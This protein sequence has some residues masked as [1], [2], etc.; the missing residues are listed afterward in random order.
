MSA[1]QFLF[2]V[3]H[4]CSRYTSTSVLDAYSK[5]AWMLTAW[6]KPPKNGLARQRLIEFPQV[7]RDSISQTLAR[8]LPLSSQAFKCACLQSQHA[9]SFSTSLAKAPSHFNRLRTLVL[10]VRL[11]LT[12]GTLVCRLRQ[13]IR[14][15]T[16]VTTKALQL[17]NSKK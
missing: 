7:P 3:L 1:S 8:T 14:R 17:T 2:T 11:Q 16:P 15:R 4:R 9:P 10:T 13:K 5:L 12:W 6:G